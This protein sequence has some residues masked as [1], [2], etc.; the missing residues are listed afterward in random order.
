MYVCKKEKKLRHLDGLLPL[1][2]VLP[3]RK[4]KKEKRKMWHLD[5]LLP[6]ARVLPFGTRVSDAVKDYDGGQCGVL[7]VQADALQGGRDDIQ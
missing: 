1:A 6:L 3:L 2:R 5:G 4:K 7:A